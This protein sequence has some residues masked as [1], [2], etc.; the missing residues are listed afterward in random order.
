MHKNKNY[1]TIDDQQGMVHDAIPQYGYQPIDTSHVQMS[2]GLDIPKGEDPEMLQL[3]VIA[4]AEYLST[5]HNTSTRDKAIR[6]INRLMLLDD[7]WDG[8]G[9]PQIDAVAANNARNII[10]RLSLPLL[11]IIRITPTETGSVS[12]RLKRNSKE[13]IGINCGRTTMS[14]FVETNG[15]PPEFHSDIQYTPENVDTLI[16]RIEIW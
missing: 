14:Y 13:S 11:N 9:A 6:Q 15:N 10:K 2:F 5:R 16:R 3:R 8:Y 12:L 4:F 7:N 1:S